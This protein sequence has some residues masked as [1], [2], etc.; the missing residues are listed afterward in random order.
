MATSIRWLGGAVARK[1]VSTIT[2]ANTWATNDT[3]TVTV[4]NKTITLTVGSTATVTQIATELVKLINAAGVSSASLSTGYSADYAGGELV[5][6]QDVTA[7]SDAGVVT[8]TADTA[9]VPF[10][11]TSGETTAGDGTATYAVA[12]A[13]TGPNHFDNPDNWEGGSLPGDNSSIIF[14]YGA[15]DCK[16]GLTYM[17]DNTF[18]VEFIRTTDYSGTIGLPLNNPAGYPEYRQRFLQLEDNSQSNTI[19][20]RKGAASAS[21]IGPT[22]LD[23]GGSSEFNTLLVEPDALPNGSS[24]SLIIID[25][26]FEDVRISSGNIQV[27]VEDDD[28]SVVAITANLKIGNNGGAS[29][30]CYVN[31]LKATL[32][33]CETVE[34]LSGIVNWDTPFSYAANYWDHRGGIAYVSVSAPRALLRLYSGTVYCRLKAPG[35]AFVYG[36]ELNINQLQEAD[37][38]GTYKIYLFNGATYRDSRDGLPT[39]QLYFVGCTPAQV[40]LELPQNKKATLAAGASIS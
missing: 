40:T 6:M 10:V 25:G 14:D 7:T 27:G 22:Y 16:Y 15:V 32:S 1:Q 29:T 38:G 23:T 4:G 30:D 37:S 17:R 11:F 5:E 21:N 2:I 18:G 20:F 24:P 3:L 19:Y 28:N 33:S 9:G 13:A 8:L 35:T 39:A 12:T 36:G 26:G 31:M 34:Q